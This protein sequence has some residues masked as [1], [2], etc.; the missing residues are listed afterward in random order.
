MACRLFGIDP[1]SEIMDHEKHP[2]LRTYVLYKT[3]YEMEPYLYLVKNPK[4]RIAISKIRTSSHKLEIERGQYTRLIT[5]IEK[6]ICH[7]CKVVEDEFHFM[8]QC[9]IYTAETDN[10]KKKKA[11]DPLFQDLLPV[12][13]F[14]YLMTSNDAQML[15][16]EGKFVHSS[17]EKR[18][19]YM[20]PWE[21]IHSVL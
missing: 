11:L 21:M 20:Q 12:D 14:A 16:W 9:Y 6:R 3:V 2:I 7:L 18:E 15:T 10:W 19:D 5:P 13:K 4:Y 17:F 8:L 1:L